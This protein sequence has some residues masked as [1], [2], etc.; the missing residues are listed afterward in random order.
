MAAAYP[1]KWHENNRSLLGYSHTI[2]A[3]KL[4]FCEINNGSLN[5][6]CYCSASVVF[7]SFQGLMILYNALICTTFEMK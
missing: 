4:H 7:A 5:V 1:L 6:M 3:C 2:S